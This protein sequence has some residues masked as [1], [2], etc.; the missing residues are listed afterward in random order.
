MLCILTVGEIF[1]ILG[2]VC[3]CDAVTNRGITHSVMKSA[4]GLVDGVFDGSAT[5]VEVFFAHVT[6][7]EMTSAGGE[8]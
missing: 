3:I 1:S 4:V 8:F 5:K 2:T 6:Y 7:W